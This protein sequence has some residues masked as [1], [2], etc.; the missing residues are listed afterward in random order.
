MSPQAML[1]MVF[2]NGWF[3]WLTLQQLKLQQMLQSWS[4]VELSQP[5]YQM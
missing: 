3:D 1:L 4:P 2:L 5:D